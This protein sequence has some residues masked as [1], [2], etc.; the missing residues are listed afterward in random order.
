MNNCK[1]KQKRVERL[2]ALRWQILWWRVW[3]MWRRPQQVDG[4]EQA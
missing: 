2:S 4:G 3:R 1:V